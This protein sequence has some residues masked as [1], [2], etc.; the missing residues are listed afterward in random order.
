MC[1]GTRRPTQLE[2][3]TACPA[4]VQERLHHGP[5]LRSPHDD[6]R[7]AGRAPGED[8]PRST[9]SFI[10]EGW[11]EGSTRGAPSRDAL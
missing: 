7:R 2:E 1:I 6:A 4:Q 10:R 5:H 8:R 3:K 9:Y 11:R